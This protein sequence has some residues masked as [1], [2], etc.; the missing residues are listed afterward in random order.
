LS[1]EIFGYQNPA[2]H[3]YALH[4]GKALQLTNILRD[5]KNDAA[6]GRIYLPQSD[7]KKFNV[8]EDEI[9][10]S[11]YS[12]RYAAL[13]TSVADRARN[14]YQLARQTLPPE[15]RRSM[16]A[17]ELMGGV[18]W[19][20]LRKLERHRFDVFGPRPVKLSKPE[21]LA[22]IMRSWL[23]HAADSQTPDYGQS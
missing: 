2:C 3:A 16:V 23:R 19:S 5:V 10:G 22:L 4:L 18:Y 13:A 21:K 15:D 9:L 7:L 1:I 14:F 6:R 11:K 17:A 20:L 8:T 12:E